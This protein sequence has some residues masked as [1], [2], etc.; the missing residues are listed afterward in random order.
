M[1]RLWLLPLGLVYG[2]ACPQK[3]TCEQAGSVQCFRVQAVPPGL[4][5]DV[6]S[7]K[8]PYN[9]IKE[10]KVIYCCLSLICMSDFSMLMELEDISL[11]SC[12]IETVEVGAFG[13]QRSLRSLD[14]QKNKLRQVPR[15]L[16]AGLE[17]LRL[18]H[19]RIHSLQESTFEGLRR[20]R[21]LELHNNLISSLRG[22]SLS[23]LVRL[24]RLYLDANRMEAVQGTL[25]LPQLHLLSMESNKIS[26]LSSAFFALLQSLRTLRL[27]GNLL[28]R[29]PHDLPQGLLH[30]NLDHNQI[31]ALR[32]RDMAQLRN[33]SVLSVSNNRLASVDGG[34]RLPN[35][36]VLEMPGN[37]LRAL[38]SRLAPRLERLD[39]GQ[40]GLQEVGHQH[41]SAMRHLKHLFL[42][43]NTIKHFEGH[44]LR[45]CFQL[46]NLA[47]EQNHLSTVPEGLPET[48]VRLDL[49]LNRIAAVGEKELRGLKRLQVLN[50]RNNRLTTLGL[51][52]LL[53]LP[54]LR[55]LYLDQNPWNCS[56]ELL[57]VK[58]TLL[59][60]GVDV[61]GELCHGPGHAPGG[62]WRASLLEQDRCEDH[63]REAAER[64]QL[65]VT[66][67]EEDYDY[68]V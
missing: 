4:Q 1:W 38:P 29:V 18:G 64:E 56:C 10:I 14:L 5:R 12:G 9:H 65:Q 37:N 25:R 32:S 43:N 23:P 19:N 41:L 68:G 61:A 7:L 49:K 40:N 59:A 52:A 54:R 28:A 22:N 30:L 27:S 13:L 46:T 16:P 26:S 45:S 34:L 35:L 62:G 50:L 47:L 51:P 24:D 44:A 60:R 57:R 31:R 67:I 21:V 8:L 55:R 20:L 11:A 17:T 42:E 3:C 6:R 58:R 66:D 39:C 63:I 15:G 33:L 48:L 36:T 2:H 53:H